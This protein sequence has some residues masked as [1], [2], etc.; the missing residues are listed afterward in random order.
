MAL[1]SIEVYGWVLQLDARQDGVAF[2]Q[3]NISVVHGKSNSFFPWDSVAGQT[4]VDS[5]EKHLSRAPT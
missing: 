5:L 2:P 1:A 3:V 4:L